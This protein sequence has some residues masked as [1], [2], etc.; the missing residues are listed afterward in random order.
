MAEYSYDLKIPRDRIAVLIGKD[1]EIK[2]A[3]EDETKIKIAVDSQEGDIQISGN[4]A[5]SLF[6]VREVIRAVGRGFNPQ[7]AQLLLRQDYVFEMLNVQDYAKN[8][9]QLTRIKGRLIGSQGKAR[10]N[11]EDLTETYICVYGK[12]VSVIGT[13]EMVAIARKAVESLLLGS[14]HKSVYAWLEKKCREM[15]MFGTDGLRKPLE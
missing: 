6:A 11:I 1:G 7:I 5:I 10:R 12:T 2:K 9:N 14:T 13:A 4:D 15:R 3:L 8:P